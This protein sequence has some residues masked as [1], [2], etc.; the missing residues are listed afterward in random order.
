[1]GTISSSL[2]CPRLKNHW[3]QCWIASVAQA[4]TKQFYR[5]EHLLYPFVVSYVSEE[6][7]TVCDVFAARAMYIQL[8]IGHDV[9]P[10]KPWLVSRV[11]CPTESF[12]KL[13]YSGAQ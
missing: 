13:M 10:A 8:W 9:F 5:K 2:S 11:T 12:T 7:Q 4:S 3:F 6:R 1:M